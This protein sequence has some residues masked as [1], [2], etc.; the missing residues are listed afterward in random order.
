[1][2]FAVGLN[3]CSHPW[4]GFDRCK[5]RELGGIGVNLGRKLGV[6]IAHLRK[7]RGVLRRVGGA[8]GLEFSREMRMQWNECI[9]SVLG[10]DGLRQNVGVI[11]FQVNVTPN[12][13]NQLGFAK[14][15]ISG[16]EIDAPAVGVCRFEQAVKLSAALF[17]PSANIDL[18]DGS[19]RI[20]RDAVTLHHP[21]QKRPDRVEMIVEGLGVKRVWAVR[22]SPKLSAVTFW[23]NLRLHAEL[24]RRTRFWMR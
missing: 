7:E 6:A 9:L 15:G 16:G 13:L 10:G 11:V 19:Q 12:Q 21:V 20:G 2:C 8:E 1:M 4:Q 24:N 22:Q 14:A 17:L 3:A 18:F 5:G 23:A